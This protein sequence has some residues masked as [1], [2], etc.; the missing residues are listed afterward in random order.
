MIRQGPNQE[1]LLDP[2]TFATTLLVL[3]A[4][5]F[6]TD[7]LSHA[8]ETV[9]LDI[10]DEF[11]VSLPQRNFDRLCAAIAIVRSNAFYHAVPDFITFCNVLSGDTF[12]AAFWDPADIYEVAWGVTEASLIHPPDD[13][14]NPFS[15]EIIGYIDCVMDQVG[16]INPPKSLDFMS[17]PNL[18]VHAQTNF[19]DDPLMFQAV[20]AAEQVKTDDVNA[21]VRRNLEAIAQQLDRA[22]LQEGDA[23]EIARQLRLFSQHVK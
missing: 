4:D 7:G 22:Q 2:G 9:L 16:M 23:K 15:P 8:P 19:G 18:A 12:D 5:R 14:E 17:R 13:R 3:F 1:L 21:M 6:G 11:R 10:E 20:Y